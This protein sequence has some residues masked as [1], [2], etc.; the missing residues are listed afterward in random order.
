VTPLGLLKLHLIACQNS[1][2]SAV[3]LVFIG[4]M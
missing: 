4:F 1:F 3:V 2:I